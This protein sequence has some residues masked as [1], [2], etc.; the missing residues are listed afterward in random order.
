M[1]DTRAI[2]QCGAAAA[3]RFAAAY[4]DCE[5]T[6]QAGVGGSIREGLLYYCADIERVM[7]V[8]AITRIYNRYA[9]FRVREKT[10]N[11]SFDNTIAWV[12]IY[13]I[14]V[15]SVLKGALNLVAGR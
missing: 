5:T 8:S 15:Y 4:L 10:Y 14:S 13:K 2:C 3:N 7:K 6:V 11:M 1:K 12:Y 9:T